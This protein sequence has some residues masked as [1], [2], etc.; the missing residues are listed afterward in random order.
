[1]YSGHLKRVFLKKAQKDPVERAGWE[2]QQRAL[3]PDTGFVSCSASCWRSGEGK[4]CFSGSLL[5]R[6][7]GITSLPVSIWTSH[8][9]N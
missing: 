6:G 9:L 1:M 4:S 7:R 8:L 5:L 3:G 2:K